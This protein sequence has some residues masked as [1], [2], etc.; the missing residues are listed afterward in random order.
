MKIV[1]FRSEK[2][3]A[4]NIPVPDIPG[5]P[6]GSSG[7]MDFA[8]GIPYEVTIATAEAIQRHYSFFPERVKK[9]L[10]LEWRDVAVVAATVPIA[11]SAVQTPVRAPSKA[12]DRLSTIVDTN[13][14]VQPLDAEPEEES[15]AAE[16]IELSDDD[17]DLVSV[18][19][20]KLLN[21]TISDAQP[22]LE[23][24]ALNTDL[25]VVLRREYLNQAIAHPELQKTLKAKA[26]E[27]LD[28]LSQ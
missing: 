19:I 7:S 12:A 5:L 9:A 14:E 10:R 18:E 25:N 20:A 11:Q 27:L 17:R 4:I 16:I 13:A 1:T 22:L 24:T 3:P 6:P 28:L 8:M 2:Y 15:P 23:A 21:K 26:A